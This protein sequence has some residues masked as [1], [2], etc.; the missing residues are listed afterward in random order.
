MRRKYLNRFLE[1]LIIGIMVGMT[2]DILAIYFSTGEII[3]TD[4]LLTVF[5]IALPFAALSELVVDWRHF[6]KRI[7]NSTKKLFK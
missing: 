6:K 7:D 4:I 3:T 1:F 5:L 2:E